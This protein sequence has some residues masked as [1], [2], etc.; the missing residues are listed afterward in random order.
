MA[1]RKDARIKVT[2]DGP[3]IV[4]GN[5]PLIKEAAIRGKD[6][7]PYEWR[8]LHEYEERGTYSLCRCGRSGDAP[9]CDGTHTKIGFDG[10]ETADMK[11]YKERSKLIEGPTVD[12]VDTTDLCVGAQFCHRAGGVWKLVAHSD[13][14]NKRDLAIEISGNCPAGRLETCEKGSGEKVEPPFEM[15]ISVTEDPGRKASGPLWVK[16]G[17]PIES[18]EGIMYEPRNRV[19][20]CRCGRSFKM[21]Y[22]DGTHLRTGFK[23][24]DKHI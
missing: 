12:L 20:L 24:G 11:L 5:V 2:K 16:G 15:S 4:T 22:C 17:I 6:G 18:A 14:G 1:A 7:V 9:Y 19:T 8:K 23:D 10:T 21:P 3:Y 13:E